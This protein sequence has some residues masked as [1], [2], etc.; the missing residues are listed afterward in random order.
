MTHDVIP[1]VTLGWRLR[2]ALEHGSVTR[3][4]M[5]RELGVDPATITRWTHDSGAAPKSGF[6]KQW[7]LRCGVPYSWLVTG[8]GSVSPPSGGTSS[9]PGYIPR[10]RVIPRAPTC[11]NTQV[12]ADAA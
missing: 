1:Q 7:A 2:I 5:A 11:V 8:D 6:V 12:W 3:Q 10:Q 4:E 9:T